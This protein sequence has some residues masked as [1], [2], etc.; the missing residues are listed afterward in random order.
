MATLEQLEAALR[1][2]DS[3]GNAEDAK[4]LAQAYAQ[5]RQQPQDDILT[6]P[7]VQAEPP[8]PSEGGSSLQ[9]AGFDTGI[10]L[11]QGATRGLAG[12]GK[13]LVDTG[14]G[15]KQ[16]G[17]DAAR[18]F[19]EE[20][21][22]MEAPGLRASLAKQQQ[23]IDQARER[24][25]PLMDTAAGLTGN[26]AGYTASMLLPAGAARGTALARGL[27][28]STV[29]GNAL[30]GAGMGAL[31]PVATGDSRAGQTALGAGAGAGGAVIAKGVG[32]LAS[33]AGTA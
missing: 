30:L 24:D 9:I 25:A 31:Q 32:A 27:L 23:E 12:F 26:V 19:V 3:A 22:G 13:A 6:L 29:G 18:Y 2:A 14:R 1:A 10:P 4:R 5:A 17:T 15:L 7:T 11:S 33:R 16:A 8:D 20:G 21:L 28:P